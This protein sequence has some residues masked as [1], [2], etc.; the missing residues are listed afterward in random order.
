MTAFIQPH[1]LPSGDS[2]RN[3]ASI[4]WIALISLLTTGSSG[5]RRSRAL[6]ELKSS[7]RSHGMDHCARCS[8]NS[9][10]QD[11]CSSSSCNKR[12]V[13]SL[14]LVICPNII[15]KRRLAF[16]LFSTLLHMILPVRRTNRQN[17]SVNW[18]S[19]W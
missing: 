3:L 14:I 9:S 19:T 10:F 18:Y 8:R 13:D 7:E 1:S 2:W 17:K 5:G 11:S 12:T 16:I 6:L 15:I 4:S